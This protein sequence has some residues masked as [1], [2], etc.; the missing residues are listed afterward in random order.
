[1]VFVNRQKLELNGVGG[2]ARVWGRGCFDGPLWGDIKERRGQSPLSQRIL[3]LARMNV[4]LME[5]VSR[6][7][8]FEAVADG[9]QRGK[10]GGSPW[11]LSR[12]NQSGQ[13]SF[14]LATLLCLCAEKPN[15]SCLCGARGRV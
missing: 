15:S 6:I 2:E 3:Y 4:D 9:C 11:G 14:V 13:G 1:M 10:H 5:M 12:P 8:C 7:S